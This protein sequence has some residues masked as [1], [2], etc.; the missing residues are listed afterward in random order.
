MCS[1]SFVSMYWSW[2]TH[3]CQVVCNPGMNFMKVNAFLLKVWFSS[4]N[5][6]C[7]LMS[8]RKSSSP[9]S[10]ARESVTSTCYPWFKNMKWFWQTSMTA[11]NYKTS[12]WWQV[13]FFFSWQAALLEEPW[14]HF[15]LTLIPLL[16]S[17]KP[18]TIKNN[19]FVDIRSILG[20]A[21]IHSVD[22]LDICWT[23]SYPLSC[24]LTLWQKICQSE[25]MTL[26]SEFSFSTKDSTNSGSK[27]FKSPSHKQMVLAPSCLDTSC[28]EKLE[29]V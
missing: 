8:N 3:M 4:L 10:S 23:C 22:L 9:S 16:I 5:T 28:Y 27:Y 2:N 1:T 14:L 25:Q 13:S 18:L 19:I 6:L 7:E 20:P 21:K 24:T 15:H 12:S 29:K 11:R 26:I 17:P